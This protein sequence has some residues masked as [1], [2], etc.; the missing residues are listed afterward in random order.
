[1]RILCSVRSREGHLGWKEEKRLSGGAAMRR[2][3]VTEVRSAGTERPDLRRTFCSTGRPVSPHTG[4]TDGRDRSPL[5]SER[6]PRVPEL[7][8]RRS[9][10]YSRKS[11]GRLLA[12]LHCARPIGQL[13][14]TIWSAVLGSLNGNL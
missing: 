6:T 3:A 14:R 4:R 1:M 12:V 10:V 5:R 7:R 8:S 2:A 9:G 13:A 11:T